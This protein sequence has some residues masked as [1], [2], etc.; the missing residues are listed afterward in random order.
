MMIVEIALA[1][2]IG[3]AAGYMTHNPVNKE[4]TYL[5]ALLYKDLVEIKSRIMDFEAKL[6]DTLK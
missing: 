2:L 1:A 6:K 5:H 3:Y 4:L